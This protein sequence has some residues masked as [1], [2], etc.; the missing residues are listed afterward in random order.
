MEKVC[1]IPQIGGK[2]GQW[3]VAEESG[4]DLLQ[5]G[6]YRANN[7]NHSKRREIFANA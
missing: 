3:A 4:A 6:E 7:T 2:T 5:T 1:I